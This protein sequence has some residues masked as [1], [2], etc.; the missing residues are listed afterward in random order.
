MMRLKYR[1]NHILTNTELHI[2]YP[3]TNY[4]NLAPYAEGMQSDR[5]NFS[6]TSS[7]LSYTHSQILQQHVSWVRERRSL[8]TYIVY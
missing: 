4:Q 1:Q 3:F 6:W 7:I 2:S 5:Q 8:L